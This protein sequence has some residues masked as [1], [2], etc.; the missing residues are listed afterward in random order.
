METF[1]PP[2]EKVEPYPEMEKVEPPVE[3]EKVEPPKEEEPPM[4]VEPPKEEEKV[5]PPKEEEPPKEVEPPK[6]EEKVEPPK[7]EEKVEPPKEE[8]KV[9]PPKVKRMRRLQDQASGG[10]FFFHLENLDTQCFSHVLFEAVKDEDCKW[11][12]AGVKIT[13]DMD[14]ILK[15]AIE[16]ERV[17]RK[18]VNS[19]KWHSNFEKKGT[20]CMLSFLVDCKWPFS[21]S[22]F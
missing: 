17:E 4:E 14:P 16:E 8:E 12:Y 11:Q 18:R 15:A 1:E 10:V 7:E 19:R 3:V 21:G 5:E 2:W 22:T 9:E 20:S 6:E 13:K